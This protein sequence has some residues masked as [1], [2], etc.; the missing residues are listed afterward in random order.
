MHKTIA[1][2]CVMVAIS[3][4]A[5]CVAGESG[6]ESFDAPLMSKAEMEETEGSLFVRGA[7]RRLRLRRQSW[8]DR[9][10]R[11]DRVHCDIIA[12]NRA[13]QMGFDTSTPNGRFVDYNTVT[14]GQIYQSQGNNRYS[15]PPAGTAGYIFT[16]G[17]DG[18][19]HLQFYDNRSGGT[20]YNRYSNSSY[21]DT[22]K[23]NIVSPDYVPPNVSQQ[24]F[25]PLNRRD[26]RTVWSW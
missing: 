13:E 7:V 15:T 1:L 14:V 5:L 17:A 16:G 23:L 19:T 3:G 24:S 12:R 6:G 21:P 26:H 9:P 18:K 25:V 4:L 11:E 20:L 10:A 22:E 2:G 8:R